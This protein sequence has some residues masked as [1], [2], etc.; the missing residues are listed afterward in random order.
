[1]T[2]NILKKLQIN[3]CFKFIKTHFLKYFTLFYNNL[4][5]IHNSIFI[6]KEPRG[7]TS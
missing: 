4:L 3:I 7:R 2:K 6:D 5:Y 1:M